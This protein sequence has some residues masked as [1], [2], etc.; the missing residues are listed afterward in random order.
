MLQK[1][2]LTDRVGI[3]VGM[4]PEE[5][6]KSSAAALSGASTLEQEPRDTVVVL[7]HFGISGSMYDAPMTGVG[8]RVHLLTIDGLEHAKFAP[9]MDFNFLAPD[10]RASQMLTV[11][12]QRPHYTMML[13]ALVNAQETHCR[14][15]QAGA[16]RLDR[17]ICLNL[18]THVEVQCLPI[19]RRLIDLRSRLQDLSCK[20]YL[21]AGEHQT[22]YHDA[23]RREATLDF[24]QVFTTISKLNIAFVTEY[25]WCDPAAAR[26]PGR[27]IS[28]SHNFVQFGGATLSV[29]AWMVSSAEHA[30]SFVTLSPTDSPAIALVECE[31]TDASFDTPPVAWDPTVAY[32][33]IALRARES[34]EDAARCLHSEAVL[35]TSDD[36]NC[37]NQLAEVLFRQLLLRY[38]VKSPGNDRVSESAPSLARSVTALPG[39]SPFRGSTM[40][41]SR[42]PLLDAVSRT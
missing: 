41:V 27:A 24:V 38:P 29:G 37:L 1:F 15:Q 42:N 20:V 6:A 28:T 26:R 21:I 16:S 25:G 22:Q 5:A 13:D 40:A 12:K 36:A 11:H 32:I 7:A 10:V 2:R 8:A 34:V 9:G 35:S 18:E 39:W 30:Q 23:I 4:P 17:Y 31:P 33:R 19:V 14:T 3:V